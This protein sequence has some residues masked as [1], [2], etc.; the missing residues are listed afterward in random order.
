MLWFEQA[1]ADVPVRD[2]WLSYGEMRCLE[3]MRV[4]KRRSDW[5]LGR[6]TAKRAIA[7]VL[8]LSDGIQRLAAIEIRAAPSGAPQGFLNDKP[9]GISISISHCTGRAVCAITWYSAALGCDLEAVEPR[10]TAFLT[11]YFAVEELRLLARTNA[12]DQLATLL[13]SAKES[14]LKALT[15]GLRMDT[16]DVVVTSLGNPAHRFDQLEAA[17]GA[18]AP[19]NWRRFEVVCRDG[20]I[21]PGWWSCAEDFVRTVACAPPAPA[22]RI[23]NLPGCACW[24]DA[25][26]LTLP[27]PSASGTTN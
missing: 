1:I 14:T 12:V 5:R 21:F 18:S 9:A 24:A 25:R 22:P 13:W 27:V 23:L 3:R 2:E 20:Q 17:A 6:W 16:R 11:D 7:A 4:P 10:S 26:N 8:G 19:E 15:T